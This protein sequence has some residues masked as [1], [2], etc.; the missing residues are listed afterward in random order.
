MARS[1]MFEVFSHMASNVAR[2]PEDRTY[3]IHSLRRLA[4]SDPDLAE[5]VVAIIQPLS[6]TDDARVQRV[7]EV[8]IKQLNTMP[9][10]S[11]PRDGV[12]DLND[13]LASGNSAAAMTMF[14]RIGNCSRLEQIVPI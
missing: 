14:H 8:V 7:A 2:K 6:Q 5:K 1:S 11:S 10:P 3:A 12:S 9:Q 4:S 13:A